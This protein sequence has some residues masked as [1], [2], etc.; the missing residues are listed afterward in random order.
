MSK[1][2]PQQREIRPGSVLGSDSLPFESLIFSNEGEDLSKSP[3]TAETGSRSRYI[4]G[5]DP[6]RRVTDAP[7]PALS[8]L[9][10]PQ[11]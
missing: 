11:S 9:F 8:K 2:P 7:R 6:A 3:A 5:D 4:S 1:V 10:R